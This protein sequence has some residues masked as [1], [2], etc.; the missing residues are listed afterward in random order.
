MKRMKTLLSVLLV[1]T[2]ALALTVPAFAAGSIRI[3]DPK[4]S[5]DYALYQIFKVDK[6]GDDLVYTLDDASAWVGDLIEDTTATTLVSKF[7]GLSFAVDTNG[8]YTV[9]KVDG[10]KSADFAEYLKNHIGTKAATTTIVHGSDP[11]TATGLDNGY[12]LI[13]PSTGAQSPALTTVYNNDISVQDKTDMPF[14]KDIVET[15][16]DENIVKVGDTVHYKITG[17][18]PA[19][20]AGDT[21]MSYIVR[22]KMDAGLTFDPSSLSIRVITDSTT[23][24][25]TAVTITPTQITDASALLS[26]DKVR[27]TPNANGYTFELSLDLYSRLKSDP[28]TIHA[29]DPIEITYSAV[30]NENA[31]NQISEN[32]ATLEYRDDNDIFTKEDSTRVYPVTIVVD[33]FETGADEQKLPGAQFVLRNSDGK[34]YSVSGSTVTWVDPEAGGSPI[35]LSTPFDA[36]ELQAADNI[37]IVTTNDEGKATFD[38]LPD[39]TYDLIEIKAPDGYTLYPDPIPVTV[40]AAAAVHPADPTNPPDAAQIAQLLTSFVHVA[41]TPKSVLPSTGGRGATML[42]IAGLALILVS[43]AYLVLRKRCEA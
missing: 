23:N 27:F 39:G 32:H 4:D 6:V 9:T 37:T 18:V 33:K 16:T 36:T 24:P 10:F 8:D 29:G 40:N 26:G 22:D 31:Y 11:M 28:A 42:Y 21:F 41:N 19:L 7:P 20:D 35:T 3:L 12:Y 1:L 43:G 14:D 5:T 38:Y 15:G 34:Y 2:L 17:M 13:I 30:V 25:V